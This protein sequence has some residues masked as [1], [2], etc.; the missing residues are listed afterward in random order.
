M[1]F[2]V[3]CCAGLCGFW[4]DRYGPPLCCCRLGLVGAGLFRY[5]LSTS[6][7]ALLAC[8]VV[9]GVGNGVFHPVDYARQPQVSAARLGHA[10]SARHFVAAWVGHWRLWYGQCWRKRC[11]G[12]GPWAGAA[13]SLLVLLVLLVLWRAREPLR[14]TH[15]CL[16]RD[17][18]TSCA[19][20]VQLIGLCASL[21]CG[22]ALYFSSFMPHRWR[23]AVVLLLG[24]A[25]RLRRA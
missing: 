12:A 25:R 19:A 5:A 17:C 18:C 1:F 20:S 3:S 8:A 4:V 21:W 24:A 9:A 7:A 13:L 14:C 22:C 15:T 6:H 2:T 10:Y 11:L 23:G 16:H